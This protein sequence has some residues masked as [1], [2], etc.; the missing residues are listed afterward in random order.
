MLQDLQLCSSPKK[1]IQ[2]AAC[3]VESP[4]AI[5]QI[6]VNTGHHDE[7]NKVRE[8]WTTVNCMIDTLCFLVFLLSNLVAFLV[9]FPRPM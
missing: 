7:R 5:E 2:E 8:E 3:N 6:E 1:Q 4:S 9:L